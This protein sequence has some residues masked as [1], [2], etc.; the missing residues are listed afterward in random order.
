MRHTSLRS[1]SNATFALVLFL[2]LS[3]VGCGGGAQK[4]AGETSG[5]APAAGGNGEPGTQAPGY[6]LADLTGK[7]VSNQEFAGKVVILDFWATWCPPC[8]EEI[9]HFVQLQSKYRDQGLVIVGL[10]LDAGGAKDVAPFAEEHNVNYPMLIGNDDVAKAYGGV[11]SIPT[12]F[13]IDRTGKI[14]KRFVGFTPPEVFEQT[15]A[16]LLAATS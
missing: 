2:A 1:R 16:P 5:G 4:D 10:S 6:E 7:M 9:P 11:N 13:V 3:L 8:R 14:V 15:I 12:T